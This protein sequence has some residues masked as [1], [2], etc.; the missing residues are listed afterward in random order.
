MIKKIFAKIVV[1]SAL[2]ISSLILPSVAFA[3]SLTLSPDTGTINQGC[4]FAVDILLDTTG[5][6][7]DGT[8][9]IL[10]YEPAKLSANTSSIVNGK[11]YSDYPGNSVDQTAGKIS[12][13]GIS[14]VSTPFNGSGI[15]A[16]INFTVLST[17]STGGST[18]LRFDFDP[19]D[20]TKTTDTNVVERGT[21]ADVLNKVK[22]GNYTIGSGSCATST[23]STSTSSPRPSS[24]TTITSTQLPGGGPETSTA[25]TSLKPQTLPQG[26]ILDSTVV[27]VSLGGLLVL[28]G[29]V[30]LT[31]L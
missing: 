20:M 10:F 31:L 27:L 12:V 2:V 29:I 14:S 30:G 15:F 6:Q 11:I 28:L 8:D 23:T 22:D 5:T 26:G 25:S 3:A 24:G 18:T 9:V 21:I 17:S 1:F 13:S 19:N 16:T 4:T 7:T